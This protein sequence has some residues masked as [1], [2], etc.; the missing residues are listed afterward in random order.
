[1]AR[2]RR[3]GVVDGLDEVK[4]QIRDL[5]VA[6]D[7]HVRGLRADMDRRFNEVD[8][9]LD[10]MDG[11][12]DKMDERLDRMDGRLGVID[13]RLDGHDSRFDSVDRQL[14]LIVT[15]LKAR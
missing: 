10:R 3:E 8:T 14:A 7:Q 15:L 9:R 1:M 2:E 11:R 6:V 5:S 13:K 4:T 12:L